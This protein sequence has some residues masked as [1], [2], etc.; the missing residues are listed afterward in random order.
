[1]RHAAMVL[2]LAFLHSAAALGQTVPCKGDELSLDGACWAQVLNVGGRA[3]A[4]QIVWPKVVGRNPSGDPLWKCPS[5]YVPHLVDGAKT[6]VP[7]GLGSAQQQPSQ[8]TPPAPVVVEQAKLAAPVKQPEPSQNQPQPVSV[9][10]QPASDGKVRLFVTDDPLFESSSFY[11]SSYGA[12]GNSNGA[13]A[14]GRSVGFANNPNGKADPRTVEV[15]SD[16]WKSC[17][18]FTVTANFQNADY[19]LWFRRNDQHRTK[20]V[21][22]FGVTGALIGAAQKVDGASLFTA[23]GDMV[24]ATRESTVGGTIKDVCKHVDKPTP[25]VKPAAQ[26]AQNAN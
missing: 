25:Q 21:L 9:Q 11:A 13:G 14:G 23:T 12:Y 7:K 17:P 1:M 24:Y 6:C 4:P 20:M 5:E 8:I 10:L 19:I 2:V 3:V 15:Q 18:Q 16:L 26:P 22:L